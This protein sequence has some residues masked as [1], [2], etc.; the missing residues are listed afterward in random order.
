M[1]ILTQDI[2]YL[3]GVGPKRAKLL[4]DELK[5]H[6]LQDL[7]YTFPYKYID[8]SEILHIRDLQEDMP[9]VQIKGQIIS[10]ALEGVGRK[11]RL[12]AIF[13]DGTGYVDIVWF[14]GLK[15]IQ[16]T[17][18]T[19]VTYLLLGKPTI[20]NQRFSFSH[21]EIDKAEDNASVQR[22]MGFQPIYSIP[23]KMRKAGFTS[24]AMT[25]LMYNAFET[26][27]VRQASTALPDEQQLN[28]G[29]L[30][31][32]ETLPQYIIS[33]YLLRP[34]HETLIAA[35]F[36]RNAEDL[37]S[38]IHRLKFEELFY[39]QLDI[40]R[41]MKNRRLKSHGLPFR[42]VGTNFMQFYN[43]HL[44]FELTGAQ[45]RVIKEI[46]HDTLSGTQMNRLLQGDVGSGKTMVALMS[47]LIALDNDFQACI[48]APTEILAEQ[49]LATLRQQLGDMP[50]RVELLTG[51]VK[52][53]K[54]RE[55]LSGIADGSIQILVGTHALIEPTV[56]F[57]NLGLV[58][59]DE[60]HRFGVKQ[61]AML[62]QKNVKPPH[63]LVMTATPIPRTLAMT[64]Y[65]DLDV[66]V[67]DE[68]P[69]GRKPVKTIHYYQDARQKL[70]D[71][72]RYQLQLG[73]QAYI[74]Y[75]LIQESEKID[76]QNLE[77][78]YEDICSYFPEYSVGK[79]HGKMP[80]AEKDE[81]MQAFIRKETQI[82]VS[83]TVIEVGVNVPNASVM[84]IWDA[85]RFGLAQLHQLRGRVGR[86]A[87]QSYCILVT[88]PELSEDTRRRIQIMTESNDGF[89]IAEEDLKLRGPGDLEGTQ[90]SG[91]PFDL[92]VANIVKD[93]ALMQQARTAAENV[94]E[95]DPDETLPQNRIL[96]K[97]L[98]LL[99]DD[100]KNYSAIS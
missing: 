87:E 80:P 51:I 39:L 15:Y 14:A 79:V 54:R 95:L 46:R 57:H 61:R 34:L 18:K 92:K 62:W 52:G 68:L 96:W 50:V 73:R 4:A 9:Y 82:L 83:T 53:K 66:S 38:A 28:Y 89:E 48:M 22:K 42:H 35:H 24:R 6:T 74:V 91:M 59:I 81:Q 33:K 98:S 3:K 65:G 55:V 41:Y 90:Q 27:G 44:P 21:P 86:G 36:P 19:G 16:N 94:L 71:G 84:A 93:S 45:K 37:P 26:L 23:E 10:F 78:G 5:V 60:Q 56:K 58:V 75:P 31:R 63:I 30:E 7:L 32:H 67:I 13:T 72:I 49:H 100:S 69:P 11:R 88:K 77:E 76:L 25:Q 99:K 20:F 40:L 64:V 8:R 1:N 85:Q 2:K 70:Y 43:E 47:C 17:Y 97:Q 29:V 12:T